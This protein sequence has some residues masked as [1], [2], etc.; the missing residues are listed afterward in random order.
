MAMKQK[1]DRDF[2]HEHRALIAVA[3]AGWRGSPCW[4]VF[5]WMAWKLRMRYPLVRKSDAIIDLDGTVT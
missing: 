1:I 4:H 2:V 3:Q 5:E